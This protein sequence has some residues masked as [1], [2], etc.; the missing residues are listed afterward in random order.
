MYSRALW[1]GDGH[2][3]LRN[4]TPAKTCRSTSLQEG[5]RVRAKDFYIAGW[6]YYVQADEDDQELRNANGLPMLL[7]WRC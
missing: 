7:V 1:I 6:V 4:Q 3:C 2:E 5:R